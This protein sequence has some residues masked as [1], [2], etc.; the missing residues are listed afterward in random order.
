MVT[1]SPVDSAQKS[2]I[3][4]VEVANGIDVF[5]SCSM[6]F[7]ELALAWSIFFSVWTSVRRSRTFENFENI[8]L[9]E[10][11]T[12]FHSCIGDFQRCL[13]WPQH[14]SIARVATL[15]QFHL[16][17]NWNAT[18]GPFTAKSDSEKCHGLQNA[19]RSSIS[20]SILASC[21][22]WPIIDCNTRFFAWHM[23]LTR[24]FALFVHFRRRRHELLSRHL[25]LCLTL[26]NTR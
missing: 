7:G 9:T 12:N 4:H 10:T 18:R 24:Y 15:A 14:S 8:P 26:C 13:P 23:P 6:G 16:L 3:V 5:L 22:Q 2:V 20:E 1:K 21:Y 11:S 19:T 17:Q 25:L